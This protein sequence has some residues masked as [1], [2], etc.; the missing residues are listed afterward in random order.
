LVTQALIDQK[1]YKQM[2]INILEALEN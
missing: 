2:K 1:N